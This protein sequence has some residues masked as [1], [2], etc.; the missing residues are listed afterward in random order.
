[1]LYDR[2]KTGDKMFPELRKRQDWG[3]KILLMQDC[4]DAY[5]MREPLAIYRKRKGSV[6]RNKASL[7]K[8]NRAI[9][10]EVLGYSR[11]RASLIMVF[12]FLPFNLA[13]KISQRIRN[14]FF[15][16]AQE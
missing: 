5:G 15:N 8:Y 1:M 12:V 6:S 3:L 2:T 10:M 11:L 9:Y 16:P 7:I 13:K 4:P 14:L